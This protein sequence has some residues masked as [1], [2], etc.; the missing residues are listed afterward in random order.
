MNY[1]VCILSVLSHTQFLFILKK[2]IKQILRKKQ[3]VDLTPTKMQLNF[4]YKMCT[5]D[6]LLCW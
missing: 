3:T 2:N 1:R 4:S 5:H 6:W